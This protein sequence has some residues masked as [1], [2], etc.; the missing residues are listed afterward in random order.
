MSGFTCP[1]SLVREGAEIIA[2]ETTDGTLSYLGES[3]R[4]T[5]E[6]AEGLLADPESKN[7]IRVAGRC[8]ESGCGQ[9]GDGRCGVADSMAS[10][11]VPIS[12]LQKLPECSIRSSC[13]WFSQLSRK[14]CELC[15]TV[16]YTVD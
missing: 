5:K 8:R 2:V 9:W 15:P 12:R 13:R 11:L 14:A 4:L 7:R 16:R 1:S 3:V 10:Q 6:A